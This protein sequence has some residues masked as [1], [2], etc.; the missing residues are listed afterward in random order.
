[1]EQVKRNLSALVLLYIITGREEKIKEFCIMERTYYTIDEAAAR[2][3]KEM[4][5][6]YDY[7]QG[8]KTAAYKKEADRA[9]DL[10]DKVAEAK[11]DRA[12][13][14]YYLADKYARKMAE[15]MNAESRIGTMCPSILIAGG[16]NFPVNK[17]KRQVAASDRNRAEW[18][19]IQEILYKLEKILNGKEAVMS[20]D[21]QAI[22]KLENKLEALQDMQDNMK[23]VNA[24]YRKHSTL[25]GCPGL[26][27][28]QVQQL[29]AEMRGSWR[30]DPNPYPSFLLTNNNANM[31]RI[32]K[33]IEE[34][35][36]V[37]AAPTTEKECDYFKVIENK[38]IMRL[39]LVFDGKPDD[40]TRSIVKHNGFVWSPK[41]Q[42]WQRTLN[43]NAQYA[44][45]RIMQELDA[46][47]GKT[48]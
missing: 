11:P 4:S 3:A 8:S 18:N 38:E 2:R 23:A 15:N 16:S 25:D 41:N 43:A 46:L 33:R 1:M 20:D 28:E 27:W 40:E 42:A 13:Y 48:A 26:S 32:K 45:K 24:Y 14:A 34:L 37:K 21:E 10:A 44:V 12:E 47:N 39:Q 19:K 22:E 30:T 9:Y 7:V 6:F 36:A 17:K 5:S 35:K 29:Q 31:R